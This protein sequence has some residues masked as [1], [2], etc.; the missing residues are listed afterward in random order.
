MPVS[1]TSMLTPRRAAQVDT[2]RAAVAVVIDG[3]G[4]QVDEHLAQAQR[5]ALHVQ[6][7]L[8]AAVRCVHGDAAR[9]PRFRRWPKRLVDH[10]QR[11]H[12]G[13]LRRSAPLPA[14]RVGGVGQQAQQVASRRA[15]LLDAVAL[16]GA[17][18][19]CSSVCSSCEKPSMA[20]SG[21]RISWPSQAM[22]STIARRGAR[23]LQ[24]GLGFAQRADVAQQHR[25]QL[26]LASPER[27]I[28]RPRSGEHLAVGAGRRVRAAGPCGARSRRCGRSVDAAGA[29]LLALRMKRSNGWP[30]ASAAA[31]AEHLLGGAVEEHHALAHVDGDDR[32]AGLLQ[33]AGG[34]ARRSCHGPGRR[35][36]GAA[37]TRA[38][39]QSSATQ[40]RGVCPVQRLIAR[41][42]LRVRRRNRLP[43]AARHRRRWRRAGQSAR[44]MRSW[45]SRPA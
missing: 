14:P 24:P 44:R 42:R 18:G 7:R 26:R 35:M 10:R 34:V 3:V 22:N 5:V 33:H 23:R 32:V 39:A 25:H 45:S 19:S 28:W 30:S 8:R 12:A 17:S 11:R 1:T 38:A 13:Q 29:H 21:V 36:R 40:R 27:E 37:A 15:D 16:P 2:D 43:A 20:F 4:Q 31:N 6:R 9:A 41:R